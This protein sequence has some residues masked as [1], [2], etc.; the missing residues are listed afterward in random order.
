[1][2]TPALSAVKNISQQAELA[3]RACLPA[4]NEKIIATLENVGK[5]YRLGKTEVHALQ[6]VNL[7]LQAKS[8]TFIVGPSG[9]GKTTLLNLIG[10]ID[11]PT[12]GSLNILGQALGDL[13]DDALSDFRSQHIG[14]IFQNFSL[15]EVLTA[16]ENIEYPL[17]L[18]GTPK[19]ERQRIVEEMVIAVGLW[20]RRDHMPEQL[21]GGQRQRVAIARALVKRPLL[22]IADEPT[23]NL[24]SATSQEILEL[25]QSMQQKYQTTF[26]FSSHDKEMMQY[27]DHVIVV[28]DGVI[29]SNTRMPA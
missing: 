20:E 19:K 24:D 25:M 21:S 2:S 4:H 16:Y 6:H 10:G 26:V 18:A 7:T 12:Q 14:F 8:F 5:V 22:V 27:A 23:A 15:I 9:C 1:M 11:Q 28:R 17:I 3:D 13:N 29:E